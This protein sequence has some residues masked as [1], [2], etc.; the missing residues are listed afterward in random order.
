MTHCCD[1][2]WLFSSSSSSDD[3]VIQMLSHPSS[4]VTAA[5]GSAGLPGLITSL[6]VYIDHR[7]RFISNS[8]CCWLW[9]RWHRIKVYVTLTRTSTSYCVRVWPLSSYSNCCSSVCGPMTRF[10]N[11][12][13]IVA[14]PGHKLTTGQFTCTYQKPLPTVGFLTQR[15]SVKFPDIVTSQRVKRYFVNLYQLFV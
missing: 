3:V 5:C 11:G 6:N 13:T 7:W 15:Q 2:A 14:A 12:L 10:L 4:S 9:R 1:A 8:C